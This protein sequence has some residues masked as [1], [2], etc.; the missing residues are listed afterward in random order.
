[1]IYSHLSFTGSQGWLLTSVRDSVAKLR[2]P[3]SNSPVSNSTTWCYGATN[4]STLLDNQPNSEISTTVVEIDSD[5]IMMMDS[6]G[7]EG[8]GGQRRR[9]W[10]RI[11]VWLCG[12]CKYVGVVL[13]NVACPV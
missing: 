5:M 2:L 3:P 11:S 10:E 8:N 13:V 1:M 12:M 6:S 4:N 7:S 9:S